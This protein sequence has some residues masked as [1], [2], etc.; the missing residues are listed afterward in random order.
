MLK[1][2]SDKNSGEPQHGDHCMKEDITTVAELIE[3][4]KTFPGDLPVLVTGYESGYECFY[5]PEI[6]EVVH[7]S[8]NMYWDGEFQIPEKGE[9]PEFSAVILERMVRSD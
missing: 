3:I 5:H 8:E 2:Q 4:L 1:S 6:Q 7:K 9:V